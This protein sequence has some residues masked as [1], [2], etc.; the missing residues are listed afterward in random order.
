MCVSVFATDSN[1]EEEAPP[2]STPGLAELF[3]SIALFSLK[4]DLNRIFFPLFI[5]LFLAAVTF[6]PELLIV[7]KIQ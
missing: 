4:C 1:A 6:T 7:R 2:S 5:I 3:R